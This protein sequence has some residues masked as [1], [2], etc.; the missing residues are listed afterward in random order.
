[1]EPSLKHRCESAEESLQRTEKALRDVKASKADIDIQLLSAKQ[2]LRKAKEIRKK[3]KEQLD[4]C[5]RQQR[6]NTEVGLSFLPP[7]AKV[8]KFKQDME[9]ERI[10]EGS[11]RMDI[12]NSNKMVDRR[13][14]S[15]NKWATELA[16]LNREAKGLAREKVEAKEAISKANKTFRIWKREVDRMRKS[17]SSITITVRILGLM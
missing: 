7:N 5:V 11:L 4:H 13:Q 16:F 15:V 3:L 1:M 17:V 2:K 12:D 9:E 10:R 8:L 6:R 14:S